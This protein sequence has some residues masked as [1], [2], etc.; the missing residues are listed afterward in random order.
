[1][2]KTES[3][4]VLAALL[5]AGI[6]TGCVKERIELAEAGRPVEF[7][8]STDW[9]ND[10]LTRTEYS[11]DIIDNTERINWVPGKDHIL[12][13]SPQAVVDSDNPVV[14]YSVKAISGTTNATGSK[15]SRA[16]IQPTDGDGLLWG[17]ET[18][19]FFHAFYPAP[20][21]KAQY[22]F[23]SETENTVQ[24]SHAVLSP[25]A[26]T[27]TSTVTV[28]SPANQKVHRDG[29]MYKAN[30]NYAYMYDVAKVGQTTG[31]VTLSFK[32]LITTF[33]FVILS[34]DYSDTRVQSLTLTSAQENGNYL[35][36]T[37]TTTLSNEGTASFS[38][39]GITSGSNTVTVAID[40][41]DRLSLSETEP[42]RIT[43]LTLPVQQEKLTVTLSFEDGRERVLPLKSSALQTDANPE[44]WLVAG[45]CK[46]IFVHDLAVS[47][48]ETYSLEVQGPENHIARAGGTETYIIDSHKSISGVVNQPVAWTAEFSEDG[49]TW[50]DNLPSWITAFTA[51]GNGSM[52]HAS[53][54]VSALEN[55]NT[56]WDG[57]MEPVAESMASARDLSCYDVYGNLWPGATE[58]T[59]YTTANCYVV[60]APGWYKLPCVYGNAI[61]KGVDNPSAYT[62]PETGEGLMTGGF[63]NHDRAQIVSPWI[64]DNQTY[65]LPESPLIE[66]ASAEVIWQ[67]VQQMISEI[68]YSGDYIY[69]YVDPAHIAEGNALIAAKD[70]DGTIVWS[71]HIWAVEIPRIKLETKAVYSHPT[72]NVSIVRP[73]DML[74]RNVGFSEGG[75]KSRSVLVRI[76]QADS[77]LKQI[78][79]ITQAGEI[80][81][82]TVT[83]QWG[84]KDP[85]WPAVVKPYP[86]GTTSFEEMEW[87]TGTGT[88]TA[89]F[90]VR[91]PSESG[92]KHGRASVGRA[93]RN[94]DTF[95]ATAASG[96]TSGPSAGNGDWC[97]HRYDNLWNTNV[98]EAVHVTNN[99]GSQMGNSQ[100]QVIRKTIYDPCPP[101]FKV[102][103]KFAFTGLTTTGGFVDAGTGSQNKINATAH[104]AEEF[105]KE[106]GY[107]IYVDPEDH[108]KG[109]I[110]FHRSASRNYLS[111]Q[112]TG[113]L[114]Y[115]DYSTGTPEYRQTRYTQNGQIFYNPVYCN[116]YLTLN[117]NRCHPFYSNNR[118]HAFGVRPV[119]D[120]DQY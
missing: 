89:T 46:K 13:Y 35:A 26:N 74:V 22:D 12:I 9:Q 77:D 116:T 40:A 92:T 94:P 28:F 81:Y 3:F 68:E 15:D 95:F 54:E 83:Y 59:P 79:T 110:F 120:P 43:V 104:S 103:N 47:G 72:N 114:S 90:K 41:A 112:I 57:S 6:A 61:T 58:G 106:Y 98:T 67:D 2:N 85:M 63:L 82:K 76:T 62:G 60:S 37:F 75:A 101:G 44:G 111:G 38:T 19:H 73:N 27:S 42:L 78:F 16:N 119:K 32:P 105:D 100:D 49:E 66:I 51:S 64:K 55:N 30:M 99:I 52:G 8:V 36:G 84:R 10:Y 7:G 102:P 109:T 11:Q 107:H 65:Y 1:M 48:T 56:G 115:G 45:A 118:G 71:W 20:G 96:G 5:I 4:R 70:G 14:D 31:K 24:A 25:V 80:N 93:T 69:F 29:R 108:S 17:L 88:T 113:I 87:W 117:W 53:F 33:E 39:P 91:T 21:M 97:D 34:S 50:T 18:N 86:A 23:G